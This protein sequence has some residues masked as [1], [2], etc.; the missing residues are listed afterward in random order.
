MRSNVRH[1]AGTIRRLLAALLVSALLTPATFAQPTPKL[2]ES[3][4][5]SIVNVDVIVTDKSGRHVTGLTADDFEIREDGKVQ[6]VTN[7]AEYSATSEA[8]G[9][10]IEPG[11]EQPAPVAAP[12][13]KRIIVLFVENSRLVPFNA[14]KMF[15]GIRDLLHRTVEPGDRV[16]I[17]SFDGFVYVRQQF[18]DDLAQLD[19]TVDELEKEAVNGPRDVSAE[20]RATQAGLNADFVENQSAGPG[21][22]S[23]PTES[24]SADTPLQARSIVPPVQQLDAA[25]RQLEQIRNKTYA[26]EALMQSISALEGK[27]ILIMAMRRFGLHAGAEY[28]GGFVPADY[29]SQLDTTKLRDS[30]I[31]TANA[32]NIALYPVYAL[33]GVNDP[34][35]GDFA[36]TPDSDIDRGSLQPNIMM[37]ETTALDDL[38]QRTGGLFSWGS[39]NIGKMMPKV[40]DDLQSYYSLAYR[41][42]A[43]GKDDNR[44]IVVKTKNPDYEVRARKQ[45]VEK[46]DISQMNDRV[47]ANLYQALPG[48]LIPFD[49]GLSKP[50]MTGKNRWTMMLRIRVPIKSLTTIAQNQT[51]AGEFGVYIATG[52]VVGVM[53]E[54][55]RRTQPFRI[56]VA[57]LPRAKNSF[58]TFD[59]EL[60][61]DQRVDRV[62]VGVRDEVGKDWGL[63]RVAIPDKR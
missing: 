58:F 39:D 27:K 37:N 7:F 10:S 52:G 12:R 38:A 31:N 11:A 8:I 24:S 61:I 42:R 13:Q 36:S 21:G 56:P 18:T 63:R 44:K 23:A 5:V 34:Q 19:T 41:S 15:D 62:S 53:S 14:K 16:T 59:F 17:V 2:E 46:S 51:H 6:P 3:I 26:L 55:E 32:H 48:S 33:G 40:A 60:K 47:M 35:W 22:T 45:V 25:T 4:E 9:A 50:K 1:E 29:R 43:T 30:L 20:V 57:D 28:F 54:V 49:V